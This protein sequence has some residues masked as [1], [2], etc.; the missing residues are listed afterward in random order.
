MKVLI[1][2]G[3][4]RRKGNTQAVL[5]MME[6]QLENG[7]EVEVLDV[8]SMKLSGC[9]ACDGCKEN[10]GHCVCPDE[11]DALVQKIWEADAVIFA[12]PVYWWGMTAQLKMAVDK[13]YSR[14]KAFRAMTK[15]MGVI[16]I[17]G[18]EV[19]NIQYQLIRHQ[20]ACIAEYLHWT[21]NFSLA[22]SAYEPGEV[23]QQADLA[24]Q[25]QQACDALTK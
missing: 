8:C 16:A 5:Q 6:K 25:V 15:K 22:F 10:G 13:L 1:L 21:L 20:F 17:G 19:E 9:V 12:T 18:S 23:L 14:D 3:S 7:N 24:Q 4:P 2:N 11:S